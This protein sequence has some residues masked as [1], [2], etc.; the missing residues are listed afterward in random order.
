M[1]NDSD[2]AKKSPKK[3]KVK[4]PAKPRIKPSFYYVSSSEDEA[5]GLK[6]RFWKDLE[7]GKVDIFRTA[8]LYSTVKA[9]GRTARPKSLAES[10]LQKSGIKSMNDEG[11]S[12]DTKQR[13]RRTRKFVE[14]ESKKGNVTASNK[15]DR[16]KSK[17]RTTRSLSNSRL[18]V[19]LGAKVDASDDEEDLADSDADADIISVAKLRNR[20]KQTTAVETREEVEEESDGDDT[21][22]DDDDQEDEEET[23]ESE[24]GD[25]VKATRKVGKKAVSKSLKPKSKGKGEGGI[26]STDKKA[27]NYGKLQK[28]V[29]KDDKDGDDNGDEDG[30]DRDFSEEEEDLVNKE[31]VKIKIAKADL[32]EKSKD[33][34]ENNEDEDDDDDESDDDSKSETRK[35]SKA[36]GEKIQQNKDKAEEVEGED[37]AEDAESDK[38][39]KEPSSKIIV[40]SEVVRLL[41]L[42]DAIDSVISQSAEYWKIH[43]EDKDKKAED[44]ATRVEGDDLQRRGNKRKLGDKN[45]PKEKSHPKLKKFASGPIDYDSTGSDGETKMAREKEKLVSNEIDFDRTNTTKGNSDYLGTEQKFKSVS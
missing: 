22:E 35:D 36:K 31:V 34:S 5:S 23:D 6:D 15:A 12:K 9:I 43:H 28:K 39:I 18:R 33:N 27:G 17:T 29:K 19:N 3:A 14:K 25:D 11:T 45:I 41:H 42:E 7:D 8:D 40:D 24:S 13:G 21:E 26:Q 10:D 16:S 44:D 20:K 32:Q 30:Q 38:R 2:K 1:E 37:Q 4:A